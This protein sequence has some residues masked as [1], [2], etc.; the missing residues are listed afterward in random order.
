MGFVSS[1]GRTARLGRY[2]GGRE[3]DVRSL[4]RE[5]GAGAAV[6]VLVVEDDKAIADAVVYALQKEGMHVKT[7]SALAAARPL[8]HACDVVVL[9][10]VLTDGSGF[11]LLREMQRL[12][13]PPRVLVLTSRDEEADCV[14]A[15]EAG[16]D[17]Y[18]T[19]P[20]SPRALVARVRAILRRGSIAGAAAQP[21]E[22]IGL[23]VERA[24]RRAS[25]KGSELVLTKIEFD[26][27]AVLADAPGRVQTRDQLVEK[28]WGSAYAL[29]P[30]TVDSHF[31]ALRRKLEHAGAPD[32]L[33]ETVRAVGFRLRGAP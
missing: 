28:V 15:L 31:K 9:D 14:A 18:V 5:E 13:T 20:F 26:L 23:L 27:L 10:L 24:T 2:W 30:R 33:I 11:S 8:L 12:A 17:D 19:K 6:R 1:D 22:P 21:V 29:T 3:E 16:A 32:G 7:V 4:Q 25:W